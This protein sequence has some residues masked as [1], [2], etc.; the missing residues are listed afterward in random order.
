MGR[1]YP[2]RAFHAGG[3]RLTGSGKTAVLVERII[4]RISDERNP[5][6]VDRSLVATFT[7]AVAAEMR[8]R[9]SEALEKALAANQ[10]SDHL[11]RQTLL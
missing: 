10:G 3:P 5:I 7:K 6:D 11:R 4:R 9:I 8:H 2:R 1:D